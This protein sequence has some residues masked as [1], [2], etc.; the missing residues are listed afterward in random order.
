MDCHIN[1]LR[2]PKNKCILSQ[3]LQDVVYENSKST[4][5]AEALEKARQV[6]ENARPNVKKVLVLITDGHSN[7]GGDPITW[8]DRLKST[9]VEIFCFGIGKFIRPALTRLASSGQHVHSCAEFRDFRNLIRRIRGDAH[10][11]KWSTESHAPKCDHLCD[12]PYRGQ[13]Q[14]PGCCDHHARCSC[15]LQSG[16]YGCVCLPGYYGLSGLPGHCTACPKGTYKRR[17]EPVSQCTRCPAGSTTAHVASTRIT[18]C[19]CKEGYE[20]EPHNGIPC[21]PIRCPPLQNP[22]HGYLFGNCDFT[23]QSE[24]YFACGE[25]FELV[26]PES[27]IRTCG[28][29]KEWSGNAAICR[30]IRCPAPVSP[31]YGQTSCHDDLVVGSKCRFRCGTG[32]IMD[33]SE[34]RECLPT[35]KWSGKEVNCIPVEC[36]LPPSLRHGDVSCRTFQKLTFQEVCSFTC[37]QGFVLEGPTY[38]VCDESGRLL[39]VFDRQETRPYCRDVTPPEITCPPLLSVSTL[40]G[41]NYGLVNMEIWPQSSD[42][43]GIQPK[44]R[45]EPN[46]VTFPNWYSIGKHVVRFIAVDNAGLESYC[47]VRIVVYDDE[48]PVVVRCPFR[49][50]TTSNGVQ[51]PVFWEEPQFDD[52]SKEPLTIYKTHSSGDKFEPGRHTVTYRATDAQ[53]NE[54]QC[55]FD[56]I[57]TRNTCPYHP[58]PTNGAFSCVDYWY[59]QICQAYCNDQHDFVANPADYYLCTSE[60]TWDT[61][62]QGL[63]VPWPDC[64]RPAI[65]VRIKKKLRG[66]YY[67]GDCN[68]PEVQRR[69]KKTFLA[70]LETGFGNARLCVQKGVCILDSVRVSCGRSDDESVSNSKSNR[71]EKRDVWRHAEREDLEL[72]FEITIDV[73]QELNDTNEV[74]Q[75]FLETIQNLDWTT[76]D[77][78]EDATTSNPDPNTPGTESV[79]FLG[80]PNY[81]NESYAG[82]VVF[83]QDSTELVCRKGSVLN[84]DMCVMCSPGTYYDVNTQTCID[85]PLGQYQEYEGQMGCQWCP[86]GT[87]TE[88]PRARHVEDCKKICQPGSYSETGLETC[89]VCPHGSYQEFV[90]QMSCHA[91]PEGKTT[92]DIGSSSETDCKDTCEAGHYSKT[93]LMPCDRCPKGFYQSLPGQI[94]CD[95]CPTN[96]STAEE[97]SKNLSDCFDLNPCSIEGV[98]SNGGSCQRV[99]RA[100]SC[101][102]EPGFEGARCEAD[103]DECQQSPCHNEATCVNGHGSFLC[104]CSDSFTGKLCE[105]EV[106]EC[107]SNPCLHNGTCMDKVGGYTCLCSSGYEG[108]KCEN[109]LETCFQDVIC[110]HGRCVANRC[111]CLPGYHGMDCSIDVD[112]CE[113]VTCLNNGSCV[114]GIASFHCACELGFT[115]EQCEI[116]IDDC[117]AN[118]CST[119]SVCHDLVG[120]YECICPPGYSGTFCETKLDSDFILNFPDTS[121]TVANMATLTL[122]SALSD[123]TVSM[124]VQ[125]SDAGHS[126]TPLSYA[127]ASAGGGVV[128]NALTV[129]GCS[130]VHVYV[131]NEPLVT[132]VQVAD[133]QWHHLVFTWSSTD[134]GTWNLYKDG[135]LQSNGTNLKPMDVIQKGG[136]IVIGQEQDSVGGSFSPF[137]TFTGNITRVNI[138]NSSFSTHNVTRLCSLDDDIPGKVVA[139]PDFLQSVH[140]QVNILDNQRPSLAGPDLP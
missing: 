43:S 133:G 97:G 24:C 60:N 81:D 135:K 51:E 7:K 67:Q 15:A 31:V 56:V 138:W 49:V 98:C 94:S 69:I 66:F 65:P 68:D 132:D 96:L 58:P 54:A 10:E 101:V 139:W 126:G 72:E 37:R 118:N 114:D 125:T 40:K 75:Q 16:M 52:N 127:V 88:K 27:H 39:S 80:L 21:S 116:N 42:N 121:S 93:G 33:G 104:V 11:T 91:C 35:A 32:Y 74:L 18:D 36:G 79:D 19:V 50:N 120:Y 102:C 17:L 134:S 20:G 13:P 29:N 129:S 109:E 71:R 108:T 130:G 136:T 78:S 85:C 89:L 12:S 47:D 119:E 112:E 124:W 61:V 26:D 62:P 55:V 6:F 140:G 107:L 92:A 30:P 84:N 1:Y 63:D 95:E 70:N 90:G 113:N 2:E 83:T 5:T 38:L 105:E 25:G 137:E 73:D 123:V 34:E 59:G 110:V 99:G 100:A 44:L 48:P 14:D 77:P 106:D 128:D 3:E 8:A 103:I 46:H 23:Y 117:E 45:I 4:N 28:S 53:N 111:A 82:S 64:S 115:G 22:T 76:E 57:V 41:Q 131:N 9:G 122:T 86:V 87:S